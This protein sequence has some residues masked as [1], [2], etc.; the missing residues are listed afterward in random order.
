MC[1]N[2]PALCFG[3]GIKSAAQTAKLAL[4]FHNGPVEK[5][6]NARANKLDKFYNTTIPRRTA[7]IILMFAGAKT[8]YSTGPKEQEKVGL[9]NK[10]H[11]LTFLLEAADDISYLTSDI[12][13]A[14]HKGLITISD[15]NKEFEIVKSSLS[16]DDKN[17]LQAI[18]D[19]LNNQ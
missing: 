1:L 9:E 11:P 18:I 2:P 17:T 4:S 16:D 14:H 3:Q 15:I 10:R 6:K 12:Q 8:H 5:C 19:A 7:N 13:D